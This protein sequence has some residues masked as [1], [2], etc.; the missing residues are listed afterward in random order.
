M[1][2]SLE[3][4]SERVRFEDDENYLFKVTELKRKEHIEVDFAVLLQIVYPHGGKGKG[5]RLSFQNKLILDESASLNQRER[6]YTR[7][8][9]SLMH[10][11]EAEVASAVRQDLGL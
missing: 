3:S 8:T 7:F 2:I 1:E 6:E 10:D 5:V 4:M 11:V 9:E